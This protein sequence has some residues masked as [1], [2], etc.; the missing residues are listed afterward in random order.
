MAAP[1]VTLFLLLVQA[2]QKLKCPFIAV[3]TEKT[4]S[5]DRRAKFGM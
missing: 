2:R 1:P 5:M 4:F 3:L